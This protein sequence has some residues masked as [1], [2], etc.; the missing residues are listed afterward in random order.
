MVFSVG[1]A[2]DL[3]VPDVPESVQIKVKREYY[4]AKQALAE[5]GVSADPRAFH[6]T[7]PQAPAPAGVCCRSGPGRCLIALFSAPFPDTGSLW[8]KW[9]AGQPA[10]SLGGEPGPAA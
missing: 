2:L 9:S 5:N 6:F 1:R 8:D 4:L 3:L 10:P 7:L